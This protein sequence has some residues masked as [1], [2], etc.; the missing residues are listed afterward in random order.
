MDP[1]KILGVS[2]SASEKEIK[3]AY[4][5]LAIKYHPD[6]N[7]NDPSA[8]KKFNEI[9]Q[10]YEHALNPPT[11]HHNP[12][13]EFG[14]GFDFNDPFSS[15]RD[16]PFFHSTRFNDIPLDNEITCKIGFMQSIKGGKIKLRYDR[17]YSTGRS[18]EVKMHEAVISIPP[19]IKNGQTLRMRGLGNVSRSVSGDLYVHIVCPSENSEFSRRNQDIFS[20]VN[21]D[22]L[23]VILGNSLQIETVH[24]KKEIQIPKLYNINTP[25]VLRGEG[26][27]SS[28]RYGNHFVNLQIQTPTQISKEEENLLKKIRESRSGKHSS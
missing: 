21:V 22:Y 27:K 11:Q 5:K 18:H 10:A 26:V 23:D 2:P 20:T 6:K 19:G 7:P 24:G 1:F 4:R 3:A 12:F 28:G 8:A 25:I 9:T 13:S 14:F 15:V 16:H 17:L